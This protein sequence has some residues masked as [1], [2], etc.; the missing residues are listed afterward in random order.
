[1][2]EFR[3]PPVPKGARHRA[4]QHGRLWGLPCGAEIGRGPVSAE[5]S[6]DG[7]GLAL[8]AS[9]RGEGGRAAG[10]CHGRSALRH[11]RSGAAARRGRG[12]SAPL[13][14]G[15]GTRADGKREERRAAVSP[16]GRGKLL[17]AR[18]RGRAAMARLS[19]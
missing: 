12:S 11:G 13:R 14:G 7:A 18:R 15:T 16:R 19:H 2:L 4:E 8:G 10:R 1:M 9:N 5:Q 6:P 17:P 3:A